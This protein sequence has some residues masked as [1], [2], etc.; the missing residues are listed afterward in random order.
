ML[1]SKQQKKGFYLYML[2]NFPLR[3]FANQFKK[4][5]IKKEYF[6]AFTKTNKRTS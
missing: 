4:M 6:N 2:A 3:D 1:E 5:K